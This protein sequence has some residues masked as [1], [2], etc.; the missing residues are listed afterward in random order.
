[1]PDCAHCNRPLGRHNARTTD[2]CEKCD[3]DG[4][5]LPFD[6]DELG[7]D[8]ETFDVMLEERKIDA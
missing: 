4:D 1:M 3:K 2:G 8:P 5:C 6:A 7:L